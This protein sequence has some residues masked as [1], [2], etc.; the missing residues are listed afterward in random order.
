MDRTRRR[1]LPGA[2]KRAVARSG[3]SATALA[4]ATGVSQ[5]AVTRFLNGDR[6]VTLATAERLC[7]FLNLEL[8][9]RRK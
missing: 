5:P 1:T 2:L 9:R 8:R 6:D 7:K 3:L 4:K